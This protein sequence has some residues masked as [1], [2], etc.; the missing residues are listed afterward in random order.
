MHG[1]FWRDLLC[2]AVRARTLVIREFLVG[3][4]AGQ[5]TPTPSVGHV[6][7]AWDM[8]SR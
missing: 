2:A 1:G 3:D 8:S 6:Q 7:P 5:A 4:R